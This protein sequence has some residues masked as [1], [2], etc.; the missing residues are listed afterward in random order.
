MWRSTR[1]L[2]PRE[3]CRPNDSAKST[4]AREARAL[5]IW[6]TSQSGWPRPRRTSQV[7]AAPTRRRKLHKD[8]THGTRSVASSAVA[9][10][11][12]TRPDERA[13]LVSDANSDLFGLDQ[14]NTLCGLASDRRLFPRLA[15]SVFLALGIRRNC[16]GD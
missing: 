2:N 8:R 6:R 15:A 11:S 7:R 14:P 16:Y 9:G 5:S 10:L 12:D 4:R 13:S 3:P 1:S